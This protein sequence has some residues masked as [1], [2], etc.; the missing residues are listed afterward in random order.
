MRS[1]ADILGLSTGTVVS[2]VGGG[3]KTSLTLAL[4]VAAM[5]MGVTALVTTTTHMYEPT[6][7]DVPP[8]RDDLPGSTRPEVVV[9]E[10]AT[11]DSAFSLL[12]SVL[13]RPQEGKIVALGREPRHIAGKLSGVPV[14]WVDEIV[15]RYPRAMVVVE[16]DGAA[17][18]PFKAPAE[19][20]PVIPVSSDI[21]L[22]VVGIDVLGQPLEDSHVHRPEK[23][24]CL[25]GAPRGT[26]VDEGIIARVLWHADG[27]AKGRPASSHLVPV[28]N[29]IDDASQQE[30]ARRVA[31]R[32]LEE[33]APMVALTSCL[34][35]PV[36]VGVVRP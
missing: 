23:V 28:L 6:A 12:D 4:A 14:E 10:A 5:E 29:K 22:A 19:H 21:V 26:L 36:V 35:W 20:E 18:R 7:R 13:R 31:R 16:A 11:L 17:R 34:K 1:L 24:T 25:T 27:S 2:L 32:L 15:R 30:A 8:L 9:L 33:G 3:G